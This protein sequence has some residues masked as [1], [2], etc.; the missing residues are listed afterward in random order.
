MPFVSDGVKAGRTQGQDLSEKQLL[1]VAHQLGTEWKQVAI[2][3]GLES[4]YVDHI[5][6]IENCVN[7][8]KLKM[9]VEWKKRHSGKAT[10]YHLWDSLK[11]LNSLP[12]EVRQMLKGM[13]K[14]ESILGFSSVLK[15]KGLC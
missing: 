6:D 13:D 4:K 8:Q 14:K 15:G 2:F 7:M 12:N 11:D 10:A 1:L 9:L 5:Q 3:L